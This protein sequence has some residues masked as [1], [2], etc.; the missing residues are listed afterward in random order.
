MSRR[1][2]EANPWRLLRRELRFDCPYYTVRT[3]IVTH[4]AGE[5]RP[6]HHIHNKNFG[7]VALAI[8]NHGMVILVGQYRYVLDRYTWEAVRGGGLLG[9]APVEAAKRE[10]KEETGYEAGRWLELFTASASPGT[11]DEFAPGFVAWD[12]RAGLATPEPEEL[13][14]V[15]RVPFAEAVALSISGEIADLAS[16]AAILAVETRRRLRQLPDDLLQLLG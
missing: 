2:D 1:D 8:D 3:D 12:L 16:I 15:R 11:C 13:I 5:P 7:I 6:Y 10:L 4:G 9:T 14:S